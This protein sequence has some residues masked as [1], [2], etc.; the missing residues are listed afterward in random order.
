MIYAR[1]RY[2]DEDLR[3]ESRSADFQGAD[4][5]E[6]VASMSE[7]LSWDGPQGMYA[8]MHDMA[9]RV[10]MNRSAMIRTTHPTV[11][12]RDLV[13]CG[14]LHRWHGDKPRTTQSDH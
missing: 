7:A 9:R 13:A 5:F 3:G 14:S 10:R 12:V 2:H 11:F 1:I 4:D 6:L 8:F